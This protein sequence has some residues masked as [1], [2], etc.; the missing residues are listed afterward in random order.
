M[1]GRR[2]KSLWFVVLPGLLGTASA[3][4]L[5][6]IYAV[7]ELHPPGA[8]AQPAMAAFYRVNPGGELVA[9]NPLASGFAVD[10]TAAH[11]APQPASGVGPAASVRYLLAKPRHFS[12][13]IELP[14]ASGARTGASDFDAFRCE[15]YGF[16]YTSAGRC[17]VPAF[18]R[19]G[20]LKGDG[21]KR[22]R[23]N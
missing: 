1:G 7:E 17:V 14:Q 19:R 3:A 15:H 2:A 9:E 16:F 5:A 13:R 20:G 12:I 8:A 6:E 21:T 23:R 10:S 11:D 18:H 22:G 4:C